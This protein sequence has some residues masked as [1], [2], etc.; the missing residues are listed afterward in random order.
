MYRWKRE[1]WWIDWLRFILMVLTHLEMFGLFQAENIY[2]DEEPETPAAD[3][4]SAPP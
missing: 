3:L 1:S 2:N 4:E